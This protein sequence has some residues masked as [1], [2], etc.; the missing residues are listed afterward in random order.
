MVLLAAVP[1]PGTAA[2]ADGPAPCVVR[3]G[4]PH[5]DWTGMRWDADV[6]CDNTAGDVRLQSFF[7]SPVVGR[8]VTTRSWFVC[9]KTGDPHQ[10]GNRIW[11]YTQGDV[12]TNWPLWKGWG[13]VP[14]FRTETEPDPFP[15][16]PACLPS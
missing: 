12:I 3:E 7:S 14:A 6:L 5:T 9:W 4:R 16:L 11:Y 2:A 1:A 15:G 8:M 10:G 13:Y